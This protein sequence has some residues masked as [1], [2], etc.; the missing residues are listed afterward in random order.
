MPVHI[1]KSLRVMCMP[2]KGQNTVI[3]YIHPLFCG[4]DFKFELYL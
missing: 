2:I 1:V 4:Q 3:V